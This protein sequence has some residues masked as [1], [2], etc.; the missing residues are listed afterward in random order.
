[1]SQEKLKNIHYWE[2]LKT[3]ARRLLHSIVTENFVPVSHFMKTQLNC[4]ILRKFLENSVHKNFLNFQTFLTLYVHILH[5][6]YIK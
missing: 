1:M 3:S 5:I 2:W 4:I 6:S